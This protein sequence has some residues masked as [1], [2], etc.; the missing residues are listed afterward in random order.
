MA[1]GT[2][3][4]DRRLHQRL[5]HPRPCNPLGHVDAAEI[6]CPR[7]DVRIGARQ[8]VRVA[9]DP[10]GPLRHEDGGARGKL[11]QPFGEVGGGFLYGASRFFSA[12]DRDGSSAPKL[13]LPPDHPG[14]ARSCLT[15]TSSSAID[16]RCSQMG[17]LGMWI[18]EV[19]RTMGE[20]S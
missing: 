14:V 11:R 3:M 2:G 4:I 12:R 8:H 1:S 16:D 9:D 19:G 5:S 15:T 13:R 17:G 7:R 18:I 6:G 20:G 10:T